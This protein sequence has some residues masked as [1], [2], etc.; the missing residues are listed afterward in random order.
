[1]NAEEQVLRSYTSAA[2]P[3]NAQNQT[4]SILW[5]SDAPRLSSEA[6]MHRLVWD[7]RAA[8]AGGRRGGGAGGRGG[9]PRGPLVGTFTV[10]LTAN[11]Q[12][13]TQPLTVRPD[14]RR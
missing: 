13:Y 2:G 8:G 11:G 3:A 14:P 7:L 12:A 4:V 6:G 5:R 10:R 1:L 9:G